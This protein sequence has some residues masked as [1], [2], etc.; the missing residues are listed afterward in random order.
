MQDCARRW[1]HDRSTITICDNE[2]GAGRHELVWKIRRNRKIE[3]LTELE[4]FRPLRVVLEILDGDLDLD[5]QHRAVGA[6]RGDIEAPAIGKCEFE[7]GAE[8][9]L[10]QD[11]VDPARN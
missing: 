5:A 6:E 1:P 3:E 8:P 7:D 9:F 10:D 2:P 4:I 11:A